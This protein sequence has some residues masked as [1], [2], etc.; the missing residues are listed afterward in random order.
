MN[1]LNEEFSKI[2][3]NP[4]SYFKKYLI[5]INSIGKGIILSIDNLSICQNGIEILKFNSQTTLRQCVD[6][7]IWMG[8]VIKKSQNE[9][10]IIVEPSTEKELLELS[11]YMIL[12]P[13]KDK[14]VNKHRKTIL[15]KLLML[16]DN[17]KNHTHR[18][19]SRDEII[20]ECGEY[21]KWLLTD[22]KYIETI[23]TIIGEKND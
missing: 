1:I 6:A 19:L 3:T 4:M 5:Y 12:C 11:K 18:N 16:I 14:L 8:F 15:I 2:G 22:K 13:H 17:E 23:K 7:W 20:K 10:I 9:L 21:E